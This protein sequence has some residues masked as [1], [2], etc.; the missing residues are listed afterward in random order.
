VIGKEELPIEPEMDINF[1]QCSCY[2]ATNCQL[3]EKD[4]SKS[5][6]SCKNCRS[7]VFGACMYEKLENDDVWLCRHCMAAGLFLLSVLI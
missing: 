1:C 4:V 6:H 7:K 2:P 5:L 3:P